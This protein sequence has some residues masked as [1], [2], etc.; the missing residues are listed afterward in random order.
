MQ[1]NN[2]NGLEII[3]KKWIEHFDHNI[4]EMSVGSMFERSSAIY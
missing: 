2:D 4:V 1:C 3:M